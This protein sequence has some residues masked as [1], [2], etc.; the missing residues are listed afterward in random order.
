MRILKY[1]QEL[2]G[3][4]ALAL[5]F[6]EDS[7]CTRIEGLLAVRDIEF[8]LPYQ[9]F[10]HASELFIKHSDGNYEIYEIGPRD[11]FK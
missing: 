11:T 7:T 3:D 1:F 5:W 9:T 10:I 8:G 6:P 2:S 4:L